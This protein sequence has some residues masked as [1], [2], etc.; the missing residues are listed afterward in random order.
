M[1][2]SEMGMA[3]LI[4]IGESFYKTPEHFIAEGNVYGYSRRIKT[5]PHGFEIGKTWVLLAHPKTILT[6]D[7]CECGHESGQHEVFGTGRDSI[8]ICKGHSQCACTKFKAGYIAGIFRVWQPV[9][10]EKIVTDKE[11][12]D[13]KEMDALRKRGIH[14]VVVPFDDKDHQGSVHEKEDDEGDEE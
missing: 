5:I 6:K 9:K 14:P 8:G 4:W 2:T 1:A 7:T 10:I 12:K 11:A 13:K 3:G